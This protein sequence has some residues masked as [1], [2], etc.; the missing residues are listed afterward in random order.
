MSGY[1]QTYDQWRADPQAFWAKAAEE[2]SWSRPPERIF[3]PEAGV[4]GRW[5]PDA[6]LN[7]CY[8]A[9]DR[10]VETGRADQPAL[11]YDSPVTGKKRT[12]TYRELLDETAILAAVLQDFGVEAGDR[13]LIYMPMIPEFDRGDARLRAHRRGAFGG[14]R[15]LRRQG[16]RHPHRRCRAESDPDRKLRH[17]ARSDRGI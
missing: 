13:V 3:D 2:I 15:R 9:L 10:H 16:A 17:R 12:L 1:R 11:Y 6:R 4:Y 14:V 5:F 8:N 7:A